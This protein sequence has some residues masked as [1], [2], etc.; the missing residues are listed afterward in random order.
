MAKKKDQKYVAYVST[1]TMG[2]SHGIR[3]YDVD[4]EHGRFI[5]KDKVEI[6]NSSY[7]SIS[8]NGKYLYSIT[9]FGVESYRILKDGSLELINFAP[10]NGMRGCYLST[11]YTDSYLFVAGYHDGKLTVLRLAKD[12]SIGAI[13][14]EIFH[15]GL[16]SVANRN[17][18]PH[19]NCARM[20]HDNKYL[21]VADQGMDHVNV[22]GFDT[23]R[24]T[25]K[26][27][28]VIRSELESAP[29]HVKISKDGRYIYIVHEWKCFIDV[30]KYEE[31]RNEPYF[32]KIQTIS[33]MNNDHANNSAAS[34]LSFSDDYKYLLSSN[35]GDNTVIVYDV[36]EKDGTL[37][38]NFCLPI[39]G[40]YPKDAEL[41]PGSKYLVSLNHESNSM[42]FFTVNMEAHTIVM[43]G[44][45]L[46]VH[47]PNC[48]VFHK[49]PGEEQ[50]GS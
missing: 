19:I 22:Y 13:T 35:A 31:R 27:V 17:S 34:A 21:L 41:F 43:N 45:E 9:D 37:T 7:L 46:E 32:D 23:R 2:D 10:I 39:S 24:G 50:A 16:G 12:G 8:H 47:E 3:V 26:L 44:P 42:T 15:K 18:R 38:K 14:D 30:Y 1:Y 29:R 20:T 33:T 5:E 25:V 6:T 11:D 48:I 49:L 4:M 28:D 40:E 36:N